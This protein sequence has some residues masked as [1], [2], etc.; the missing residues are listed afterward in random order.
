[1]TADRAPGFLQDRL[2]VALAAAWAGIAIAALPLRATF[3]SSPRW[4]AIRSFWDHTSGNIWDTT[5]AIEAASAL[6]QDPRAPMYTALA[7]R[8]SSFIY[9]PLAAALYGPFFSDSVAVMERRLAWASRALALSILAVLL[10][11]VARGRR[12]ITVAQGAA[13]A[14]TLVLFHPLARAVQLNQSTLL[15]TLLVGLAWLALRR[16]AEV[17]AGAPLALAIAVKPHLLLVLPLLGWQARK[18]A[19]STLGF[20]AALLGVSLAYAG[21]DNHL[22]YLTQVLPALGAGY[23]F[24]PNQT[25]SSFFLRLLTDQPLDSF[26]IAPPSVARWL[27]L[28]AAVITYA[29]LLS[30]ARRLPRH[31]ALRPHALALLSQN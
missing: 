31:P 9:P 1:M 25:F 30:A 5:P 21:W 20:G 14:V 28:A 18:A 10:L 13:I 8:G 11:Y 4:R 6:A 2:R 24:Y 3:P 7:R 17:A 26:E 19:L 16:G 29:A 12:G 15:V 23:A 22:R 27:S